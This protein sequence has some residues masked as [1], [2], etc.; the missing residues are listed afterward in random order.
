MK[1]LTSLLSGGPLNGWKTIVGYLFA[2]LLSGSPVALDAVN[3]ALA[4]PTVS[5]V[6][7]AV[8]HVVLAVGI[9]HQV[10]KKF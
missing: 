5:N 1:L 7:T 2:N 4:A 8:A 9:G 6:G 3:A 10:I